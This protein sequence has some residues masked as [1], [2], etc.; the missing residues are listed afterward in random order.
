MSKDLVRGPT[1]PSPHVGGALAP[2]DWGI[3]GHPPYPTTPCGSDNFYR[4]NFDVLAPIVRPTRGRKVVV[5]FITP[6]VVR[7][8]RPSDSGLGSV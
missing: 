4:I 1:D 8:I 6:R 3:N 7:G 5:G 2:N